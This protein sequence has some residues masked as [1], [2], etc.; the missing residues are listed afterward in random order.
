MCIFLTQPIVSLV[1]SVPYGQNHSSYSAG[2]EMRPKDHVM[3]EKDIEYYVI[4][5]HTLKVHHVNSGLMIKT[6]PNQYHY[7]LLH[8]HE[9]AQ[10]VF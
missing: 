10:N 2:G 9:T 7:L 3:F 4:F 8:Y 5:N 1:G 6:G